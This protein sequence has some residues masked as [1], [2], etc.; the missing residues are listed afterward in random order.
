MKGADE[1]GYN[2]IMTNTA[3]KFSSLLPLRSAIWALRAREA[4]VRHFID[5]GHD[6]PVTAFVMV[7]RATEL[8]ATGEDPERVA[9]AL[10]DRLVFH[11]FVKDEPAGS[12]AV[13]SADG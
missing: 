8:A 5:H 11:G 9:E 10:H 13:N 12:S 2:R 3:G 4:D 6:G 1:T 7:S